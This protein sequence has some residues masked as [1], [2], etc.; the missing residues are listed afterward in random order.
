MGTEEFWGTLRGWLPELLERSLW[1]LDE[2]G[3][4]GLQALVYEGVAGARMCEGPV[5]CSVAS[6]RGLLC[7]CPVDKDAGKQLG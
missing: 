2:V 3:D 6:V 1:S 4:L 5:A 7:G